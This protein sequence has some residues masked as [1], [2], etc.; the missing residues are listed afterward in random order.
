MKTSTLRFIF[1]GISFLSLLVLSVTGQ[2]ITGT[3]VGSVRD[4][5]G[6]AVAG[7]T[8]T[9]SDPS[10]NNIVVRTV[11]TN[12]NGEF[13]APNL[14]VSTYAVTVE[15]PNFKKLV[16][17]D[18]KL[19]VGQRRSVDVTLEAGNIDEV[20]TVEADP[21]AVDLTSSTSGTV[22]SGDQVR[23]LSINNRNFVQLVTLAPGV[24][25]DLS[26]QVYVGTTNPSGQANIVQIAV[27]GAR[28]SQNTFTVDGADVTDRGSNLTIQAYPSVDSIGEFRVLRSLYPA[29]SGRSGGGQ[30]NIVT[31][32]GTAK[33]RGSIFE[34]IRNEAF[35]ANNVE[36]NNLTNPPLGRDSNGKAKRTPFRYN[37]YGWTIG[38]PVYFLRFGDVEPGA[39]VFKRYDRTFFFFS[40]EWRD[41]RRSST[42]QSTVPNQNQRNAFFTVPIC[43]QATGTTCTQVLP[44]NSTLQNIN[45]VA[46]QYLTFI[47]NKLPLPNSGTN[48]LFAPAAGIAEFRQ[49]VIKVD[50]SFNDKVS[51]YYRFQRDSIPTVD[52]NALF[53]S[54]SGLPGVSTTATDSP[55]R[56][57][58]AQVTWA[59]TPKFIIEGRYT[60]GYG[61]ILSKNVG[62]I[63][64]ANSPITPPLAYQNER[65]R[66]PTISGNGFSALQGFG[67]YDNFSW[68]GNLSGSITWVVGDHTMK[69]GAVYSKYRKNEN[70]LAGN[71]E[72]I[73]SGFNTPGGT[74]NVIAPGGNA[75][76]QLWANFL[77][78]TNV[79]FTQASFD[80]TAD[81]RQ[82]TFEAFAQDE[83]RIRR[84]LTFYYGVRYS[85]FGAPWDKNG[86]LSNFIPELY[87]R[88]NA[89]LV[90]G[91]G[92]RVPGTGNFC[93]GLIVNSQNTVPF[94]NC[95]PTTSPYGKF[96]VDVPKT[97]FAPRVGLAWDPFGDG[98]TAVRTGYGIYHEQILNGIF[99]QNI[100]TNPPY[101]QTC[102]VVGTRLDN[103]VPNGC[104]VI[105]T[106]TVA[107]V[108]AVQ[109]D[110][111]T[112]YMQH[113]SFDIQRQLMRRTFL[114]VGYYGSKGTHLIGGYGA[115]SLRPGQAL[116]SLCAQGASTTPTVPCQNP[117]QA[118]LSTADS[119]ILDQI[120]PYR[121]YR[122][123]TI[124]EP[125]YNSNYHSMQVS[126]QHRLSGSSQINLA[127]TWGKNLSDNRTD[128]SNAPQN[129]YDTASEKGRANLDR[130]HVLT[131]NYVY[132]LPFYRAQ[133]GFTGKVLG[134]WQISGIMTYQTGLGFTPTVSNFDPAGLG[135]IPTALTVGRPNLLCNPNQGGPKNQLQW[136]NTSCFQVTPINNNSPHVNVPGTAGINIIEGPSTK[137]VD[138]TLSKMISFS[139]RFRLQLRGE[140]FNVFNTTNPRG[141]STVVWSATTQPVS[142]G[143]NGSSTFGQVIS[144]RDPR[145]MQFGAKF[146]F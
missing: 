126:A 25:N 146:F 104:A 80:Y 36:I 101:Q 56:T 91:A 49:E 70:A 5:T 122:S 72:G 90:T 15:A 22:I 125:R 13:T 66:V 128:R 144:W 136:F 107:S 45:P 38:G 69:F 62:L 118:F 75:T 114:S 40:Q 116:N 92:N 110:W 111:M 93:E 58:T 142:Q 120:R 141:L 133:R 6:A 7:A 131:I 24:T 145:I 23:E 105:A 79:T 68:K 53:S 106:N 3:I 55:G 123:V 10:K 100:G 84:N 60:F 47:Y 17:T 83:W 11:S 81:L 108:R 94:P 30:V 64:L 117:G 73:F 1:T 71:N 89:P 44:A 67:P 65:D 27:N 139:E 76:Q 37:N 41:D 51:M 82:K 119:L 130:R 46:Q 98:R 39:S 74:A 35:N 78:G 16:K 132:E 95:N 21:I 129:S 103:P 109:D 48:T 121:G 33:F 43:L 115:N 96:V 52:A 14:T 31:R 28:S 97:D 143:G 50:H 112:P 138:F 102:Q 86:R 99:L 63:A 134:G 54:G 137:R 42:L 34:F 124:I 2:E 59:A 20:V 135:I 29:E 18:I 57:H 85:F 9:I 12:S 113:W 32:S 8:V 87:N 127:Y 88:A 26:D 140:A 61:G 77:M 4:A 19:D